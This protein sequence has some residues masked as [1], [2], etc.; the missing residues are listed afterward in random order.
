MI[1]VSKFDQDHNCAALINYTGSFFL[2]YT[3]KLLL[4][5]TGLSV[6]FNT[7]VNLCAATIK[8]HQSSIHLLAFVLYF[9]TAPP[10]GA[11][12]LF[13]RPLICKTRML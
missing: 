9:V 7:K 10:A 5:L 11:H 1:T 12:S 3:D 4:S 6:R 2:F 13:E 8:K